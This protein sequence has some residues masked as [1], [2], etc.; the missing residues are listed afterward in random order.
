MN[1][2]NANDGAAGRHVH[3]VDDGQPDG[4]LPPPASRI[5][6]PTSQVRRIGK[7]ESIFRLARDDRLKITNIPLHFDPS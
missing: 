5:G 6:E 3:D 2:C 7:D 1:A 4:R